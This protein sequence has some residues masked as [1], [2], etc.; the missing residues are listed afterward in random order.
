MFS[1]FLLIIQCHFIFSINIKPR[2]ISY[3]MTVRAYTFTHYEK[4]IH[5]RIS[6]VVERDFSF[7]MWKVN[8]IGK[9]TLLKTMG[10][11]VVSC[12]L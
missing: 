12:F 6:R 3:I 4:G 5:S 9:T 2:I 7:I 10:E 1:L 8:K 11:G